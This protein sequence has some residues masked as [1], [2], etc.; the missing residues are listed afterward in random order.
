MMKSAVLPRGKEEKG[1]AWIEGIYCKLIEQTGVV[2]GSRNEGPG[3][4][5][6]PCVAV[7]FHGLATRG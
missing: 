1:G 6:W 4:V 5:C 7:L 3:R 2:Y